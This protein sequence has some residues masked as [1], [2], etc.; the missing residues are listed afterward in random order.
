MQASKRVRTACRAAA[1][2]RGPR[3]GRRL[4][5]QRAGAPAEG[6]GQLRPGACPRAAPGPRTAAGG[7]GLSPGLPARLAPRPS[8]TFRAPLLPSCLA[9][10][11]PALPLPDLLEPTARPPKA[12]RPL[13]PSALAQRSP[14]P[15]GLRATDPGAAR[16]MMGAGPAREAR[17]R[18][19]TD[20][21]SPRA[22]AVA[23]HAAAGRRRCSG[24]GVRR[25]AAR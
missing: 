11:N 9:F 1:R 14:P 18:N 8:G 17:P 12:P 19:A 3:A 25:S 23:G 16:S 24:P 22:W 10:R 2:V 21:S 7:P 15:Q 4:G 13:E 5:C 6:A 20:P